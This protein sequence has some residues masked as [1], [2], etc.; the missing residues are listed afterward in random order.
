M[1]LYALKLAHV[2]GA[3]ADL[4]K[5][6]TIDQKLTQFGSN[7]R[8]SSD[9]CFSDPGHIDLDSTVSR[10]LLATHA[11]KGLTF[12]MVD[13]LLRIHDVSP[14]HHPESRRRVRL[15]RFIIEGTHSVL[16]GR[17]LPDALTEL[18]TL[19]NIIQ[20]SIE[21]IEA[22]VT[23]NSFTYPSPDS[24]FSPETEA[25]RMHPAVLS[26]GSLITS[27]AAQLITLVRP[28]PLTLLDIMLQVPLSV[29]RCHGLFLT[30]W[31]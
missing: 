21:Q 11:I 31:L 15:I 19:A 3:L 27:A 12:G 24:I 29:P 30:M 23:A 7:E 26:A 22:T 28:A 25:P 2:A 1:I 13:P 6:G 4:P 20:S 17:A 14:R 8:V 10:R 5:K 18:K 9:P 16:F